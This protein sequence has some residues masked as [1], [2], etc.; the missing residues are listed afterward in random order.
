MI[1]KSI[2]YE[3]GITLNQEISKFNNAFNKLYCLNDKQIKLYLD[4]SIDVNKISSIPNMIYKYNFNNIEKNTNIN[5]IFVGTLKKENG[6]LEFINEFILLKKYL[7]N[8]NLTICY[9]RIWGT[10]YIVDKINKL[11][12]E[13]KEII[14][15]KIFTKEMIN[16]NVEYNTIYQNEKTKSLITLEMNEKVIIPYL[17]KLG[18]KLIYINS[19]KIVNGWEGNYLNVN[20][21]G[22]PK[23][24]NIIEDFSKQSIG[25]FN[26]YIN[27]LEWNDDEIKKYTVDNMHLSYEG[28]NYIYNEII[29]IIENGNIYNMNNTNEKILFVMGNGPSLA[30]IMNNKEYLNILR[31]HDTFGLNSA[32]RAYEKY[33]FYPTYFGCFDYIVNENHKESFENMVISQNDIKEFYFIGN[34]KEGQ[35]M[36]S[37][38]VLDNEKFKKFN[39][40]LI[41]FVDANFNLKNPD[42]WF[43]DYTLN[44]IQHIGSSGCD[45][46]Q[47]GILKG[48]KKIILLGCDCNYVEKIEG[49]SNVNGIIQITNKID[50]NPNYWFDE[51]QQIGDKFNIPN[52]KTTQ[53]QSWERLHKYYFKN[54]NIINLSIDSKIPYFPIKNKKIL[55]SVG[56]FGIFIK[57][58]KIFFENFISNISEKFLPDNDKTLFI[59][60]D[61]K[62]YIE[63]I[64]KNSNLNLN[65]Y[66]NEE[67]YIGWP[68]ETLYRFQYILNFNKELFKTRWTI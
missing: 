41:R 67:E 28:S 7:K 10:K 23:N 66:I 35:N 59:I 65:Y 57:E 61:D 60:T 36:F 27:L 32:Y 48:Y 22:R 29:K 15:K 39:F 40:K 44:T 8:I 3:T 43:K 46:S 63:K 38:K 13:T 4:N 49:S 55:L 50:K 17:Q 25:K 47:I 18:N 64:I 62:N 45:A 53:I 31:Q 37:K 26:N 20:S 58:Y 5:F 30:E 56:I 24:I 9:G 16:N 14:A 1:N 2:I 21:N 12:D 54:D 34:A 52:A 33:N 11:I 6:I 42:E 68:Y 51:Y 19:N